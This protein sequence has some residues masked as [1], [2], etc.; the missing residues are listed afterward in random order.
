MYK[1]HDH[2]LA[3]LGRWFQELQSWS[4]GGGIHI[5]LFFKINDIIFTYN[6]HSLV[7]HTSECQIYRRKQNHPSSESCWFPS[8]T[9]LNF[10]YVLTWNFVTAFA[11]PTPTALHV[12]KHPSNLHLKQ[13]G[14]HQMSS[15]TKFSA[16]FGKVGIPVQVTHHK[17]WKR[18]AARGLMRS[19]KTILPSTGICS[20]PSS[21]TL[22]AQGTSQKQNCFDDT[23][24]MAEEILFP[25]L[26]IH[27]LFSRV[28]PL[29]CAFPS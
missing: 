5:L 6:S 22:K 27:Q 14:W 28:I 23:Q 20:L 16:Y 13:M 24:V 21:K 9:Y 12:P 3:S 29:R 18:S 10:R 19:R 15:N 8:L 17:P 4:R 26:K 11:Q 25:V 2:P 7:L 1:A